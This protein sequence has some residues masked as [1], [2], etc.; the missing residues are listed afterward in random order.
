MAS[1]SLPLTHRALVCVSRDE[2]FKLEEQRP[3]PQLTS[4]SAIV[5]VL[6]VHIISYLGDIYTG[7]RP[8]S[9]P[10]PLVPGGSCVARVAAVGPD[11]T[12]LKPGQLVFSHIFLVGRDDPDQRSLLGIFSGATPAAQNLME[13]EWRDASLAE[14]ARVP[15]ENC[16]PLDEK[17]LLGSPQNGGLGYRIEDLS[18]LQAPLVTYGGLI[19]VD[20]KPGE[21]IVVT[22]AT[23]SFGGS[24]VQVALAMGAGK[25]IAMG[26]NEDALRRL[27]EL[28]PTRVKTVRMTGSWESEL[29]ALRACGPV[30]AFFDISP[31]LAQDSSHFK[32]CIHSLRF[33]GR[34]SLMGG[35]PGDLAVPVTQIVHK[36]LQLRGKW[37][38]EREDVPGFM[39]LVHSGLLKLGPKGGN[40]ITGKF[41][42]ADW[43]EAF[44]TAANK[45]RVGQISV[46]MP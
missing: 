26:R 9:F 43:K 34:V 38:Y 31:A 46:V 45:A 29:E 23:G 24:A 27:H 10:T 11:A 40:E 8:L 41:G 4:G 22:P 25:V 2:P 15:M 18:Y 14:Y 21:T 33:G 39:R 32:S 36:N 5:R 42:L 28:D 7:K 3:V 12:S 35:L 19:D 37:M 6:A 13:H 44:D 20:L 17:R 30:D 1:Q 16:I